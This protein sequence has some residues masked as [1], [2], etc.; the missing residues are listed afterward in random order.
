MNGVLDAGPFHACDTAFHVSIAQR[1][2][3]ALAPLFMGAI[4]ESMA[5]L[6]V[7][8]TGALPDWPAER[9]LLV[10]EHV[11][12]ARLIADGKGEDAA[13]AL[14]RHIRGFYGRWLKEH[15]PETDFRA[16]P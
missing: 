6:M 12:I 16:G 3:N 15:R 5:R 2:G 14:S 10:R 1:S 7:A 4:R 8:A 13:A 11:E 9:A